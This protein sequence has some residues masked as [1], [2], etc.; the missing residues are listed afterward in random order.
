MTTTSTTPHTCK[1]IYIIKKSAKI[2]NH[3]DLLTMQK[4]NIA[5]TIANDKMMMV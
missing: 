1:N 5:S 4:Q 2:D 3:R